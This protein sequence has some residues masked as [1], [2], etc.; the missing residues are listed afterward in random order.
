[1]KQLKQALPTHQDLDAIGLE[2][3]A[4]EER[5]QHGGSGQAPWLEALRQSGDHAGSSASG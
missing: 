4:G 5:H 3:D 2:V 1:M